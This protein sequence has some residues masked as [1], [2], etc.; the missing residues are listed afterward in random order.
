VHS[1]EFEVAVPIKGS[2]ISKLSNSVFSSEIYSLLLSPP[3]AGVSV[4][5]FLLFA[6]MWGQSSCAFSSK[7]SLSE[8]LLNFGEA[9]KFLM[10]GILESSPMRLIP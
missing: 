3:L 1:A 8:R 5:Y 9:S 4:L 7:S 10:L 2:Y 6:P